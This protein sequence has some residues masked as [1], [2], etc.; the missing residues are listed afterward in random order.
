MV[1][2][3]YLSCAKYQC[4]TQRRCLALILSRHRFQHFPGPEIP[5]VHASRETRNVRSLGTSR[6][7]RTLYRRPG[8]SIQDPSP[9]HGEGGREGG[10]AFPIS[11]NA[12]AAGLLEVAAIW[13]TTL[14]TIATIAT[15]VARRK[16]TLVAV[17]FYIY[18]KTHGMAT[19][20]PVRHKKTQISAKHTGSIARNK[21]KY[22]ATS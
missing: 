3:I 7:A 16:P 22:L 5:T 6:C 21:L 8:A 15:W 17:L 19:N 4:R 12:R 14:A 11:S 18:R 13:I 2:L 9:K 20:A 1:L 10:P